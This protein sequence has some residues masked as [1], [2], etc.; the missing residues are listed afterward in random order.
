MKKRL[1]VYDYYKY[2]KMNA[3]ILEADPKKHFEPFNGV[4]ILEAV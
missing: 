2:G 3:G 1:V 4:G